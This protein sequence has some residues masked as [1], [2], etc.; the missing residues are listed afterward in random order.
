MVV[1]RKLEA[2]LG[3]RGLA[4]SALAGR[5]IRVRGVL[6][7]S[8]GSRIELVDPLMIEPAEGTKPRG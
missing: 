4:P 1:A 6:D 8:F 5:T 3:R 7:M 2:A